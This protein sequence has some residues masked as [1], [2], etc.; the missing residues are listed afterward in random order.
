MLRAL[1]VTATGS[2]GDVMG[3]NV[4]CRAATMRVRTVFFI[5]KRI[6]AVPEAH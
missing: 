3:G 1:V 5:R 6:P 4:D 2:A